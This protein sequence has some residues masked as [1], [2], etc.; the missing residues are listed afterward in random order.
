MPKAKTMD[1]RQL[2]QFIEWVRE[3][4]TDP[5]V[6]TTVFMLS[7]YQGL[8][9][10]EIAGLEWDKHIFSTAPKF[11]TKSFPVYKDGKPAFTSKGDPIFQDVNCLEIDKTISKYTSERTIPLNPE[12]E[13]P[14]LT[15]WERQDSDFVI[16]AGA[17]RSSPQLKSRAHALLMRMKRAYIKCPFVDSDGYK[18]HS[19]RRSFGTRSAQRANM[20][21][22]SLR[23]TQEL[24]GHSSVRT[25]QE[26][27]DV[28]P[29]TANH[30]ARLW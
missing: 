21:D 24:L 5:E 19:G 27:L 11:H 28:S 26:Y 17:S 10:Q 4:T 14:L 3:N 18:S 16:P 30:V 25:T 12:L 7:Y 23:D 6:M 13:A 2:S 1:H 15:L 22:C 8:R 9:V 20:D 29:N